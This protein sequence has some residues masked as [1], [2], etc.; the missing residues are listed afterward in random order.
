MGLLPKGERIEN[1]NHYTDGTTNRIE[2]FTGK[3][4][5]SFFFPDEDEL[6]DAVR[7]VFEDGSQ[8]G[9][10]TKEFDATLLVVMIR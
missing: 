2:K 1:V 7:I 4:I 9:F 5:Q 10:C 8:L 3:T 6:F